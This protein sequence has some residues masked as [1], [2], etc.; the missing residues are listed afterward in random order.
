VVPYGSH[1]GDDPCIERIQREFLA[2]GSAEGLD[3]SCMSRIGLTPFVL[4]PPKGEAAR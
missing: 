4:E 2:R 1:G 3:T